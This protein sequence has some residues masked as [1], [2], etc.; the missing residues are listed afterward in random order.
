MK[1]DTLPYRFTRPPRRLQ[2]ARMDN[3]AIVPASLLFQRS[4]VKAA[5]NRLPTGSVLLCQPTQEKQR[6]TLASVAAYF[7]NH[8]HQVITISVASFTAL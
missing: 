3:I 8:G 5:A 1:N 4:R 7:R 6:R 2:R